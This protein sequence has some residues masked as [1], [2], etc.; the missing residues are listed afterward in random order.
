MSAKVYRGAFTG[1]RDNN[2]F[3]DGV[4]NA[5]HLNNDVEEPEKI[6]A[7]YDLEA[8]EGSA[9]VIFKDKKGDWYYVTGGHCSCYGLED[10]WTP[11]PFDL[12]L[13]QRAIEQGKFIW[14]DITRNTEAMNWLKTYYP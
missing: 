6:F 11:E 10:Q 9:F 5:F 2:L 12:D 7:L 1:W 3:P 13:L 8:Y 14:P 4:A